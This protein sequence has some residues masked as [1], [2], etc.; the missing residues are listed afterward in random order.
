MFRFDRDVL[1]LWALR[2]AGATCALIAALIFAFV[3]GEAFPAIKSVGI[4]FV[5]DP[6]W[7][8]TEKAS[9]GEFNL[10][11]MAIGSLLVTFGAVAVAGPLGVLSAAFCRFYA[12]PA[13]ANLYRRL[14]ELM[15][16]VPSVVYGLWGLVSLVPLIGWIEP[17]GASLLA[18]IVVL[19]IM[20]LPTT[21]LLSDSALAG[22]PQSQLAA[23]ASLGFSRTAIV[24]RVA[25]P[26]ASSGLWGAVSLA[27]MR[28]F[29][30]TMAVVM[31]CGNVVQT[32][33]SLFD[34]MRT[35]TAAIAL[36]MGYARG[37]HRS[38]LF[39]CGLALLLVVTVIAVAAHAY[40][41]RRADV[42][43]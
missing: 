8:P 13:L 38:A 21:A 17:P 1:F 33:R 25:I 19:A 29:G 16:G 40:A 7:H 36:E 31:V 30:E 10:V 20:A 27:T 32:P 39:V 42:V 41:R 43:A 11:P 15:A 35:L 2:V 14:I 34:P 23:A 28:A 18:G 26:A 9:A 4:R 24:F 6:A 37:D 3:A 12:P 5:S 22:V